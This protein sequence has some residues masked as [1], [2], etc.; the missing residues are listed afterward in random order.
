[1]SGVDEGHQESLS[2][3]E[4]NYETRIVQTLPS[5]L[6]AKGKKRRLFGLLYVLFEVRGATRGVEDQN[7]FGNFLWKEPTTPVKPSSYG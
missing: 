7:D 5:Y 2:V 3:L 1:M 4:L 6:C